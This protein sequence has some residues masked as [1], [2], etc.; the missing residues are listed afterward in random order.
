[1]AGSIDVQG[2]IGSRDVLDLEA[3]GEIVGEV[4]LQPTAHRRD[5][6]YGLLALDGDP[7]GGR[8]PVVEFREPDTHSGDDV[9]HQAIV[10]QRPAQAQLGNNGPDPVFTDAPA[11][12]MDESLVGVG[13][14]LHAPVPAQV[15]AEREAPV[16]VHVGRGVGVLAA[17]V[18]VVAQAVAVL[19]PAGS[20]PGRADGE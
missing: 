3:E 6:K 1:M 16:V 11:A 4:V 14:Q 5:R 18:E 7:V 2:P 15:G 9:R 19:G 17:Q 10:E 8:L 12:E 20:G 13:R